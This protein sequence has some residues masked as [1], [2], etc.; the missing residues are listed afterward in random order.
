V[1]ARLANVS[2][3][4]PSSVGTSCI[5]GMRIRVT[6]VLDLLANGLTACR[7]LKNCQTRTWRIFKPV[8]VCQSAA[9]SSVVVRGDPLDWIAQLSPALAR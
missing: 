5:R 3:L 2:P 6:D 7:C 8:A 1:L 9:Q 4:I